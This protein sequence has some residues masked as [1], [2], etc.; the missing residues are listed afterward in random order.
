MSAITRKP[1]GWASSYGS[2]K[3]Y[4]SWRRLSGYFD[5]GGNR[6]FSSGAVA[7]VGGGF[8]LFEELPAFPDL[9]MPLLGGI[10]DAVRELESK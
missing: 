3:A 10:R 6:G 7:L 8:V 4:L 1:A 9:T 5:P 2:G